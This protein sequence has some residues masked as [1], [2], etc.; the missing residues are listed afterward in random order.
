MKNIAW[1]CPLILLAS[2]M[3][4]QCTGNGQSGTSCTGPLTVAPQSGNNSQSAIILVDI[5]QPAPAPAKSSYILSIVNG[6]IQESDNGQP[7]HPEAATVAIGTTT[8]GAPGSQATVTN[9]G[10]TQNAVFN[11]TIPVGQT[12]A[13]GSQGQPGPPGAQG[14]QGAQGVQGIQG[15]PGQPGLVVG[16]TLT[17]GPLTCSGQAKGSVPKGFTVTCTAVITSIKQP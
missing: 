7:Y 12:G 5:E 8:M 2:F 13:T 17:F 11:F 14:A 4:A 1:L 16:D 6:I 10:T 15:I 3:S 9:S